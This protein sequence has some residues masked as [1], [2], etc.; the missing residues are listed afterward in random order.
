MLVGELVPPGGTV[1]RAILNGT[2]E[3]HERA[4]SAS[5]TVTPSGSTSVGR[6]GSRAR[7]A[8]VGC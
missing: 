2:D 1:K 3:K 5:A 7:Y 6:K 8:S 4:K